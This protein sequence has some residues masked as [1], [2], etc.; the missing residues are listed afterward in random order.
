MIVLSILRLLLFY[1]T[2]VFPVIFTGPVAAFYFY[3]TARTQSSIIRFWLVLLVAS[4]V[5]VFLIG[6]NWGHSWPGSGFHAVVA[7]PSAAILSVAI[8]LIMRKKYLL[9]IDADWRWRINYDTG[10]F[11][12][13]ILQVVVSFISPRLVDTICIWLYLIGFMC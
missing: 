5:S 8:L 6:I 13:P 11:F 2:L 3:R 7:A 10:I 12:I 1:V 9:I 4:C